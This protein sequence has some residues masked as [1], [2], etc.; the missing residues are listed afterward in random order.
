MPRWCA[1][2][3]IQGSPNIERFSRAYRVQ[4]AYESWEAMLSR[5]SPDAVVLATPW[6]TTQELVADMIKTGVPCLVEKPVALDSKRLEALAC[7]A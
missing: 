6:D 3:A 4:R 7:P 5:G 1:P 2:W